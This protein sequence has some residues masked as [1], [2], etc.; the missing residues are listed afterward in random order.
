MLSADRQILQYLQKQ[1]PPLALNYL[2][3]C[4][5]THDKTKLLRFQI[6]NKIHTGAGLAFQPPDPN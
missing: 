5:N 1:Y 4:Q 3:R 2:S 6:R